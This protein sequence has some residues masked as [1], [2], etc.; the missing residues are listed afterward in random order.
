[1]TP[2]PIVLLGAGAVTAVGD[3]VVSTCAAMRARF[4][5]HR[6]TDYFDQDWHPV[7]ASRAAVDPTLIGEGRLVEMVVRAIQQIGKPFNPDFFAG[8]PW[9]LCTPEETRVGRPADDMA[10]LGR[11]AQQLGVALHPESAAVPHGHT[12]G[13]LALAAAQTLFG[14][15]KHRQLL[16]IATDSLVDA[17][18]LAEFDAA[19]LLLTPENPHGFIPGEAAVALLV[20]PWAAT[21]NAGMV[22]EST[23]FTITDPAAIPKPRA[24]TTTPRKQ[25]PL[26][27]MELATAIELACEQAACLPEDITLRLSDANGTDISFKE[28]GL[29]EA[30]AFK[31]EDQPLPPVWLPAESVGEIGAAFGLLAMLWTWHAAFKGYLPGARALVHTTNLD[32]LRGAAVLHYREI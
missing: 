9:I 24:D 8:M 19:G 7:V 29:A 21:A 31:A 30:R 23:A 16:I 17:E 28:S 10:L 27:G 2:I 15:N 1:M 4:N 20:A 14:E 26:D 6:E 5:N 25:P 12:A 22:V 32:G 3:D 11:I 13:L 18:A